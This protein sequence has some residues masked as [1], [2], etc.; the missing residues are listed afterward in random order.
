M[1]SRGPKPV[2][3]NL[4]QADARA[5][6]SLLYT[7]RDGQSGSMQRV[8][9]GPWRSTGSARWTRM[10]SG[11]GFVELPANT[12]YRPSKPLGPAI[13][14][15][16][17]NPARDLP[18]K[19]K[20][21]DWVIFRPVMPSPEIWLQLKAARSIGEIR[22]ASRKM[23]NWMTREF[24]P[25]V[26]RWLPGAPPVEFADALDLY[27]EK[28]LTGKHLPAYAKT[29]RPS[30]DDKRVL[31]ISKVLAGA[32][33]G[34]APITAVKRLSHWHF[35]RDWAEKSLKEY[36]DWS[37]KEFAEHVPT[38]EVKWKSKRV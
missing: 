3:M 14:I 28:L 26:G 9:W 19:L 8:K 24:G 23:R 21:K 29:D 20:A 6:A 4:L 30:S 35:P 5:W 27:A 38:V 10:Q 33:L 2:D 18:D 7:L 25:Q 36:I 22:K 13:Y 12:S 34:L 16:V 1:G 32:R 31:F 15:P 17:S 11:R 37:Q